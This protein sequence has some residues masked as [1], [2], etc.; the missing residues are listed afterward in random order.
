MW[1]ESSCAPCTPWRVSVVGPHALAGHQGLPTAFWGEGCGLGACPGSPSCASWQKSQALQ[2]KLLRWVCSRTRQ[3]EIAQSERLQ[4]RVA[5]AL[6]EGAL[7]IPLS[8][9]RQGRQAWAGR[10]S[11]GGGGL[12]DPLQQEL[13][14]PTCPSSGSISLSSSS[15]ALQGKAPRRE[16]NAFLMPQPLEAIRPGWIPDPRS[17]PH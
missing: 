10:G 9:V 15:H 5:G 1:A 13:T 4:A 2:G 14:A 3:Q 12:F 7:G 8:C 11:P 16:L 17:P 6:L